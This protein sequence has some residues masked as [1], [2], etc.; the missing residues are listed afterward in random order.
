MARRWQAAARRGDRVRIT[1]SELQL[2]VMY[3][4]LRRLERTVRDQS[5]PNACQSRQFSGSAGGSLVGSP[6]TRRLLCLL[7]AVLPSPQVHT[8]TIHIWSRTGRSWELAGRRARPTHASI[9]LWARP[10]QR[11]PGP[12]AA[13]PV[14]TA[15]T[16]RRTGIR[17]L[18]S[19][20]ENPLGLPSGCAH[21]LNLARHALVI[22]LTAPAKSAS[23]ETISHCQ[24]PRATT[25]RRGTSLADRRR[26][27]LAQRLGVIAGFMLVGAGAGLTAATATVGNTWARTAYAIVGGAAGLVG[28]TI[29]DL[30]DQRRQAR[31]KAER[32]RS[33]VLGPIV[34]EQ[35]NER[36][37]FDA[38]LATSAVTPFW[39]RRSDLAW[40]EKWWEDP[41]AC[42]VAVVTGPA[43]VGKTRLV[44][45]FAAQR[46]EPWVAGWLNPGRG[47][48]AVTAVQACGDPTLV[49]VD[50]ADERP[51]STAVL[52]YLAPSGCAAA[53]VRIELI[54]RAAGL[55]ARLERK[56]SDWY[57]S[58]LAGACERP[59]GPF[60]TDDDHARWF[61]EAVRAYAREL[62]TPP[63]DLP[64]GISA[65]SFNPD[66]PILTVQAQALLMVLDSRRAR[67][68]SPA[69][70]IL[71]FDEVAALLFKQEEHRWHTSAMLPDWGLTDL[72][73]RTRTWLSP[74]WFCPARRTKRRPLW[75]CAACRT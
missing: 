26:P 4:R 28:G 29:M 36:S 40:L 54:S 75:C 23:T 64:G 17:T 61:G 22:F 37:V 50:D 72:T 31:A 12:S 25:G 2:C 44:T 41:R 47:A 34:T 10:P 53:P 11:Q 63:P 65:R 19:R 42:P 68:M 45:H 71:P 32:E 57:R 7:R 13:V 33:S 3:Q 15:S 59:I 52:E 14:A 9:H 30:S 27:G 51:D 39:D 67:P 73:S 62:K 8:Q 49:V 56:L 60:G 35:A 55:T 48:D 43:G 1:A 58:V 20:S 18:L 46:P 6:Y 69:A 21:R 66:E 16:V 74:P 5:V 70:G 24:I 38:L